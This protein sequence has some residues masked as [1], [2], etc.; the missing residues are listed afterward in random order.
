[1]KFQNEVT[2]HVVQEN[3]GYCT[4]VLQPRLIQTNLSRIQL[5]WY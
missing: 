4:G 3:C 1:M 5:N 2:W